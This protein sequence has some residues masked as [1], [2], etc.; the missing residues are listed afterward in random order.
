MIKEWRKWTNNTATVAE[1][2]LGKCEV[3]VFGSIAEKQ[4]TGGSDVDILIIAENLPKH[5]ERANIIA[6]IEEKAQLPL[7]HPFEIHLVTREESKW[8]WRHIRKAIRIK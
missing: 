2:I 6:Q 8:Y 3:Y 4:E 7:Y 1:D 5:K